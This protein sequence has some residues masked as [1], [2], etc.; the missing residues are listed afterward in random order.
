[1]TKTKWNI[2]NLKTCIVT[3]CS[4]SCNKYSWIK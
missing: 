4:N 3:N 2:S 1:M